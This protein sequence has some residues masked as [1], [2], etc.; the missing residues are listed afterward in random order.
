MAPPDPSFRP[1]LLDQRCAR[2]QFEAAVDRCRQCGFAFCGECL[3]YAFGERQPPYCIP[4][5]LAAAGVRAGA[6]RRPALPKREIRR[7]EREARRA[8]REAEEVAAV[9]AGEPQIDWSLPVVR[10]GD[11]DGNVNGNGQV[12]HGHPGSNGNGAAAP[13]APAPEQSPTT[14]PETPGAYPSFEDVPS[15]GRP[16]APATPP[17]S[18]GR[19]G[20]FG[21]KKSKAVPF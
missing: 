7:R 6:A 10:G 20:L 4:C 11:P 8:A 21:R 12:A 5:A 1:N 15:P 19:S 3:V 18:P 17:S 14:E 13:D 16:Q 9:Q 2:H